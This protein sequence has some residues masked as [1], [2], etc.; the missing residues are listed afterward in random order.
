MIEVKGKANISAKI[1]LD[2]TD[3]K[4]NRLTTFEVE[5]PRYILSEYNT[6]RMFSRNA[7][8]TRAIP[9][10]KMLQLIA[11]EPAMPFFYGKNQSGMSAAEELDEPAKS[12]CEAIIKEMRDFCVSKV[13]ELHE[14]GLH[15]QH[16]GR[17]LEPWQMVKGV[18]SFTEGDNWYWLRNHFAA[19]PEIA[20]LARC[21]QEA[22][23]QSVPQVLKPGEYHLPYV[24]SWHNKDGV[25]QF[26]I[27]SE[28]EIHATLEQAIKVSC[29]RSCA[30]SFRNT[31]YGLEKS[32][33][34]YTRLVGDSHKHSSALEHCAKV[35][36]E[37]Y[38]PRTTMNTLFV[39]VP[40]CSDTWEQ[41]ISHADREGRLWSGN[42]CGFVQH[43]K[44]IVG[45]NYVKPHLRRHPN[46]YQVAL[47]N[48]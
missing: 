37:E 39:N 45:E 20:E 28:A 27:D 46:F 47:A 4:G 14:L 44:T 32:E 17:Y 29:A 40:H 15:K 5:F 33:E 18:L 10:L 16:A 38:K 3:G 11:D 12:A 42:Y 30:V 34:V 48:P 22:Q 1:V 26:G 13:L 2:S 31:D 25:Q 36:Q 8:S 9:I 35:M 43:R 21:M 7:S 6:H 19:Q 41:G 23:E 24:D